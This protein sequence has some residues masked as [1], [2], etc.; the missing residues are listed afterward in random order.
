[1]NIFWFI[2]A[3]A[4]VVLV[5]AAPFLPWQRWKSKPAPRSS[6]L[7]LQ[8]A[9]PPIVR[10]I[11]FDSDGFSLLGD[12]WKWVGNQAADYWCPTCGE[13]VQTVFREYYHA[14]SGDTFSM[15][16]H[17]CINSLETRPMVAVG[18]KGDAHV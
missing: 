13:R 3:V 16:R 11:Y 4:C 15:M 5:V 18:K 2:G 1:M 12:H 8:P 17:K 9:S 14:P 7:A 10:E 6:S